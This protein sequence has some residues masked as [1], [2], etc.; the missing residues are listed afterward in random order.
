VFSFGLYEQR[1]GGKREIS[2][3]ISVFFLLFPIIRYTVLLSSDIKGDVENE[4]ANG[5]EKN[6]LQ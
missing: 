1:H 4:I 3:V 5:K 6:T 2:S